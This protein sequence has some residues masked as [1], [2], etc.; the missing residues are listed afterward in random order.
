VESEYGIGTTFSFKVLCEHC[1][2]SSAEELSLPKERGEDSLET[3]DVGHNYRCHR[4]N[5]ARI[6]DS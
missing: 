6:K 4:N 2:P 3:L 5:L 1:D